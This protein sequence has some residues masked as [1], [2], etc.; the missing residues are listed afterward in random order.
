MKEV[1]TDNWN[2]RKNVKK[3]NSKILRIL[4]AQKGYKN[5]VKIKIKN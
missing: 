4:N 2:S 5:S 1:K 3:K